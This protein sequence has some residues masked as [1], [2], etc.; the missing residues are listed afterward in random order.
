MIR[1]LFLL[2]MVLTFLGCE[3]VIE[4]ELP[5]SET[6][7][8][9]DAHFGLYLNETPQMIDGAVILSLSAPFFDDETPPANGATVFI[10]DLDLN[11]R[12]EFQEMENSGVYFPK[13][14]DFPS[15]TRSTYELT[16]VYEGDTY[17][18]KAKLIP[19]VP[20]DDISQ[21][22]DTLFSGDETEIIVKFT[23]N[24]EREDY[25]L[26][27]LGANLYLTTDDRFYNGEQFVFSYFYKDIDPGKEITVKI[28]GVDKQF[29]DYMRILIEQSGQNGGG[30]FESTPSLVRGN[31]INTTRPNNFPLGYFSLSEAFKKSLV[32][33]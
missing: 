13:N 4:V 30:P 8:V 3:D 15:N 28:N 6:K 2:L 21:G 18:G 17:K 31:M 29:Y 7:L 32:I 1:K 12:Y 25:Y 23:D 33:E 5:T 14:N 22:D 20:I 19:S 16:V 9:I 26:F 10:T 11:R 24:K 27:T